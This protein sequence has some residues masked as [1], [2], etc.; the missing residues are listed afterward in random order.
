[1]AV[2]RQLTSKILK[3]ESLGAFATSLRLVIGC[4]FPLMC[5]RCWV[6]IQRF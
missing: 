6:L 3:I 2:F 4:W 5:S 1:M